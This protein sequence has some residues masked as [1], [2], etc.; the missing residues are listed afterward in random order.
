MQNAFKQ[1]GS[2]L[3]AGGDA[4]FELVAHGYQLIDL[5]DDAVLLGERRERHRQG[6]DI[7]EVQ[8]G[9]SGSISRMVSSARP[10]ASA[11]RQSNNHG[12]ALYG[13]AG[14]VRRAG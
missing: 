1:A 3:F 9:L 2:G 13:M 10:P 4:R 12:A 8:A 7:V 14:Q 5:G 6:L 11:I